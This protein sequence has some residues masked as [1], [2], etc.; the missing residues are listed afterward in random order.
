MVKMALISSEEEPE[1]IR[2]STAE[3]VVFSKNS[4]KRIGYI[5]K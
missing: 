5:S 2:V 3:S 1:G 4:F